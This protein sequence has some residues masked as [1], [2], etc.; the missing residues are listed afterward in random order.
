MTMTATMTLMSQKTMTEKHPAANARTLTAAG[1]AMAMI[2]IVTG[3]QVGAAQ[4]AQSQAASATEVAQSK[5]V[6]DPYIDPALAPAPAA[7]VPAAATASTA[8]TGVAAAAPAAPAPA[9]PAAPAPAAPAP[10]PQPP[11]DGTTAGSGG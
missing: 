7:A 10:A 2:A 5:G 4:T 8:S 9:A 3:F 1:T 11:A 6:I